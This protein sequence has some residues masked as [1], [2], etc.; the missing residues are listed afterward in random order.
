MEF[1]VRFEGSRRGLEV[2]WIEVV[3]L[4][5]LFNVRVGLD[6]GVSVLK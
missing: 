3:C 5:F 4:R 2:F 6:F 1:G